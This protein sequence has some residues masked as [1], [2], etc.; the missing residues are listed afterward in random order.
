MYNIVYSIDDIDNTV[1]KLPR[2]IHNYKDTNDL[3][4]V[5]EIGAFNKLSNV[6]TDF[7]LNVVNSYTVAFLHSL[8]ARKI[9]L[10]YELNDNQ[11][12]NIID[13]YKKRYGK[14]P[15]LELIVSCY[16]E[17]MISKF[18][19]NKYYNNDKIYLRD[20]FGNKYT[21]ITDNDLMYIYNYKKRDIFSS[22]YYDMGI[23]CL[24]FNL[25]I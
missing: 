1:K 10:S 3:V 22:K 21:V 7:S 19:L 8:G 14:H 15:N 24:R 17:V 11:I 5:G 2:V 12:K 18:S 16:E 25:D 23:N 9:C 20:M 4:L 6:D 13:N